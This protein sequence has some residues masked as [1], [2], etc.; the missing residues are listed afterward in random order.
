MSYLY[1]RCPMLG[2][3][4]RNLVCSLPEQEAPDFEPGVYVIVQCVNCGQSF[5]EPAARLELSPDAD[6]RPLTSSYLQ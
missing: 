3:N 1:A 5:R 2:C 4:Y 6:P